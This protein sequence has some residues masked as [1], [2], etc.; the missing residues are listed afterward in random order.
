MT[1]K[2]PR[3][4][5]GMKVSRVGLATF[6]VLVIA[7][8]ATTALVVRSARGIADG[9]PYCIQVADLVPRLLHDLPGRGLLER[10]VA[11]DEATDQSPLSAFDQLGRPFDQQDPVI[12]KDKVVDHDVAQ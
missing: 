11:V 5:A 7:S 6:G 12:L 4:G 9:K 2:R 3:R 10:L 8:I 1:R